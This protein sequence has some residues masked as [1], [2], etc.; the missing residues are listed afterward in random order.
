MDREQPEHVDPAG[1]LE[2]MERVMSAVQ[3]ELDA[4]DFDAHLRDDDLLAVVLR[5]HMWVERELAAIVEAPLP[6][7]ELLRARRSY[8][9]QLELV[10]ALGFLE[11][12]DLP[13]YEYL[14]DLRNKVAHRF[15]YAISAEEQAALVRRL[16][17][18]Y[19][20]SVEATKGTAPFPEPL[21]QALRMLV[22][23]LMM[24]RLGVTISPSD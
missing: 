12:D 13:A 22:V 16:R 23:T 4:G 2:H 18:A 5:A 1:Q 6:H 3:A 10:G 14:D 21:K 11:A 24:K 7:P 20:R 15:G 8:R 9:H 19:R 17:P